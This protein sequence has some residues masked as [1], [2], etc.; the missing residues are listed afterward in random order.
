VD[1]TWDGRH[2]VATR[3]FPESDQEV[4]AYDANVTALANWP[5]PGSPLAPTTVT[6]SYEPT[7]NHLATVTDALGNTTSFAYY[8][9][10]SGASL[11][12]TA[13]RPLWA[14]SRDGGLGWRSAPPIADGPTSSS[15]TLFH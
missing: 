5:K 14:A 2:R 4:F 8:A 7:W 9:S 15:P 13:T 6:A 12:Q 3:T 10:G 11:M 1:S